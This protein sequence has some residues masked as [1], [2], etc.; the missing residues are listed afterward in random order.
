MH[1]EHACQIRLEARLD[2]WALVR[3][4][5][6]AS[7]WYTCSRFIMLANMAPCQSGSALMEGDRTHA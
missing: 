2:P 5:T 1:R 3:D 4:A 6:S 7:Y